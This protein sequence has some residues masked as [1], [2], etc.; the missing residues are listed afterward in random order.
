MY[1]LV[2]LAAHIILKA[3]S[4]HPSRH[5]P[6]PS[7]LGCCKKECYAYE[8]G[9]LNQISGTKTFRAVRECKKTGKAFVEGQN[10]SVPSHTPTPH[11]CYNAQMWE[12]CVV[13]CGQQEMELMNLLYPPLGFANLRWLVVIIAGLFSLIGFFLV[14]EL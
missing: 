1:S 4:T 8:W 9:L 12:T 5:S 11:F 14:E 13:A 10:S 3:S 6:L 7:W 2:G